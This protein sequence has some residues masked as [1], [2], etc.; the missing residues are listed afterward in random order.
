VVA[1]ALAVAVAAFVLI[2]TGGA[3]TGHEAPPPQRTPGTVL[4]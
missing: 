4:R 3:V 1:I 2:G